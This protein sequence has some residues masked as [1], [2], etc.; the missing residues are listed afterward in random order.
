MAIVTI[1]IDNE[2]DLSLIKEVLNR[3]DLRY[4]ID[5]Q[6]TWERDEEKLYRKLKQS[7]TLGIDLGHKTKTP[8][9]HFSTSTK[10]F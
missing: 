6:T 4:K 1:N 7:P 2:K 10:Y 5:K 8:P 9:P 3:F